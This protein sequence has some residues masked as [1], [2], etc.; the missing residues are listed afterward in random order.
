MKNW[1]RPENLK[2]LRLYLGFTG[3]YIRYIHQYTKVAYPLN[4]LVTEGLKS[5]GKNKKNNYNITQLWTE[6]CDEAFNTLKNK[7]TTAP[8][9][10][11]PNYE[12][13]LYLETDASLKGLG[14]VLSH[15]H[16]KEMKVIAYANRTLKKGKENDKNCFTKKLEL[17]AV[18]WAVCDAFRDYLLGG[19]CTIYTDNNP[20]TY[21]FT[22]KKIPEIELRWISALASF[23]INIKYKPGRYNL[24]CRYYVH[25]DIRT[26]SPK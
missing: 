13:E 6:D 17:L 23:N 18:K 26:L 19:T 1:Q 20:L 14:A 22:Q 2:D 10:V 11:V 25:V 8:I 15:E 12:K 4:K 9:L 3:Y 21:I 5:L 7:L 16:N 24:G